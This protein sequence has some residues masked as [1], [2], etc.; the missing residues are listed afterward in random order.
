[1]RW[2]RG[3]YNGCRI[4]GLV[5]KARFDVYWWSLGW[6][7]FGFGTCLSIGPLHLWIEPAYDK[8]ELAFNS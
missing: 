5:V 4:V 6:P 3:K 7:K 2:P 1:M 8:R